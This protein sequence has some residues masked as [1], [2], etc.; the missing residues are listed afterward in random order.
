MGMDG[1]DD[2][3]KVRA[4]A[5]LELTPAWSVDYTAYYDAAEGDFI[6]QSYTLR[7]DLHCW[8]AL[9]V[10]QISDTDTGFYFRINI[11]ELPDIK[12]EQHVTNF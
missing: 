1:S 8:E 10:R 12:I 7:R 6:N 11:T 4:S 5:S 3:S 9:F 2:L